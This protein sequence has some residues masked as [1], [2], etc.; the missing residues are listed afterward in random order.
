MQ[1]IQTKNELDSF[2][3]LIKTKHL[4]VGLTPTM[5]A[6]HQG[7]I[8]LLDRSNSDCDLSVVS[9]FVN[10]MQ[11]NNK[12][13]LEKY[14]KTI[15]DDI[16]IL[17]ANDCDFL[18]LPDNSFIYPED[19]K[20]IDLDISHLDAKMEGEFR[21][22]HFVGVVNVVYRLFQLIQPN[23]AYF[24]NKDFQQLSI[25]AFMTE[26]LNLP[27]DIIGCETARE[28]NGLAMSSRNLRLSNKQKEEASIIYQTLIKGK[29]LAKKQTPTE[30]RVNM[31]AF[32]EKSSLELEYIEII[33]PSTLETLDQNW[34]PKARVCIAAFCG[35]VRLIDNM[36]IVD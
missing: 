13:D 27:I 21:P 30:T 28:K 1:I 7:H 16:A 23:K 31:I 24:G 34:T 22:G 2:L 26:K 11:F 29:E 4:T 32:F 17:E 6:L 25:I 5:G 36:Q 15:D 3:Q 19:F 9:I 18:F 20:K 10:P 14:P 12:E 8:S 33:H 35:G